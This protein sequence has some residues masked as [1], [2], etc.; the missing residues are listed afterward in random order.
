MLELGEKRPHIKGRT[1]KK[2][3]K[4]KKIFGIGKGPFRGRKPLHLDKENGSIARGK[5]RVYEKGGGEDSIN[6]FQEVKT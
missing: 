2:K 6:Y 1:K 5:K 3:W 4:T